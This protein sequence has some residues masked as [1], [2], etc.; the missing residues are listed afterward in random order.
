M[1]FRYHGFSI[2]FEHP[3]GAHMWHEAG[4]AKYEGI[5]KSPEKKRLEVSAFHQDQASSI[6]SILILLIISQL[7]D[8]CNA[9]TDI[10]CC[11]FRPELLSAYLDTKV[12][13]TTRD[14]DSWY[15]LC[16]SSIVTHRDSWIA[17]LISI[18]RPDGR[19]HSLNPGNCRIGHGRG[20]QERQKDLWRK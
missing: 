17:A 12:T 3:T 8:H 19:L 16:L 7:L 1:K 6:S 20:F 14:V 4:L 10:S 11:Q 9:I 2:G 18:M 13:L 15:N 5:G